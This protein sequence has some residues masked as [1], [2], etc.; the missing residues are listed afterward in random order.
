[1]AGSLAIVAYRSVV[2]GVAQRRLDVQVRWFD[3]DDAERVRQ[4]IRAEPAHGYRNPA[5]EEVRWELAE[6][7]EVEPFA[8]TESGAEV[9]GFIA[10]IEELSRLV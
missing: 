7:F 4:L 8:P 10:G 9:A 3:E 6:I 1:M 2:A 5:G